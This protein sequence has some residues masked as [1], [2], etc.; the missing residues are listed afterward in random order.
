MA[1]C[2]IGAASLASGCGSAG[3][4]GDASF[5][6]PVAA[7]LP[8]ATP[9]G[10]TLPGA[11]LPSATL[12]A[13]T[14]PAATSESVPPRPSFAAAPSA[15]WPSAATTS[16]LAPASPGPASPGPT[17]SPQ[18]ASSAPEPSAGGASSP[19]R[20][21]T[22]A[23]ASAAFAALPS[24]ISHGSRTRRRIALTF[25]A[26]MYPWMYAERGRVSLVDPRIVTL[27]EQ[28]GT[29]AT[30]FL[31]GL[32]VR[33]Y[34][35]LVRRL[36]ADPRIE[37][38]N[39]SWDHAGW[40]ASCPNTTGIAPPM[41]RR[42]EVTRTASIIEATTGVA[43]R[44][45]RFPGFCRTPAQVALVRSLGEVSISSDCYFGD[46]LLWST[47]RQVASVQRGCRPGSIVVTHLNGAPY[48]P[49]V[50]EALR[51]LIPWWKAHGWT[52][53]NVGMMLGVE[54]VPAAGG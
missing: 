37:L 35:S 47:A 13:A 8:A 16:S 22:S 39:H 7:T 44:F 30:V 2:L 18:P 52:V 33:A 40:T 4:G 31:N 38:A 12:P 48:H 34:P 17:S 54:P 27:L 29:P 50:Y 26:D 19:A 46:T 43:P 36:A 20:S 25:D 42:T 49:N 6:R 3:T 24:D 53:V 14:L 41:T 23:A 28:T 5:A 11:T 15:A 10:T 51:V 45:F 1:G 9:P 21:P 32:F